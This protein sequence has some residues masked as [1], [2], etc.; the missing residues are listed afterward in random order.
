MLNR[1]KSR[2]AIEQALAANGAEEPKFEAAGA[3]NKAR[4]KAE[5]EADKSLETLSDIFGRENIQVTDR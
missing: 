5:A 1:E 3:E 4:K 2:L